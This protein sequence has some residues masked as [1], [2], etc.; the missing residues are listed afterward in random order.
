MRPYGKYLF[1]AALVALVLFVAIQFL[2]WGPDRT[3]PEVT[4]TPEWTDPAAQNLVESACYDCHSNETNWPWY[5]RIA[6]ISWLLSQD[7]REGRTH[8]NF[9]EFD[10]FK[11]GTKEETIESVQEGE[12]PPFTYKIAHI[13]AW[14]NDQEKQVMVDEFE[15]VFE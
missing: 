3:N 15:R 8:L 11:D 9:S 2:P 1:Y 7:V 10:R 12:M 6:P 5:S 14:L 13:S 4:S